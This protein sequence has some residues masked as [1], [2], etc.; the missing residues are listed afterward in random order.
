MD[1]SSANGA[2]S[3]LSNQ[4]TGF[5]PPKTQVYFISYLGFGSNYVAY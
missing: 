2:I 4:P 5:A 3:Y 1:L